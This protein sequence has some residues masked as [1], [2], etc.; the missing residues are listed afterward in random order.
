M[1]HMLQRRGC[2][3]LAVVVSILW[4]VFAPS[5]DH[6][7]TR[8]I[9]PQPS[10]LTAASCDGAPWPE[11][12]AFRP[13]DREAFE[14]EGYL[15]LR[16][17]LSPEVVAAL[18]REA[19]GACSDWPVAGMGTFNCSRGGVWTQRDA[20]RDFLYYGPVGRTI[21]GLLQ[22]AG[23]R[24]QE[25]GVFAISRG[26]PGHGWHVDMAMYGGIYGD[27][28]R[29]TRGAS[30]FVAL[31]DIDHTATGGTL[32]VSSGGHKTQCVGAAADPYGLIRRQYPLPPRAD[33]DSCYR[34]IVDNAVELS[35]RAGDAMIYHPLMP[36][37]TQATSGVRVS[38]YAR[39]IEPDAIFCHRDV[40]A[41]CGGGQPH[42]QHP[43]RPGQRA[44]H[45][46]YQQIYPL[47]A[48]E[49]AERMQPDWQ[50]PFCRWT[51]WDKAALLW[52]AINYIV[53]LRH[54]GACV[55]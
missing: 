28:H 17:F 29:S 9:A 47:L 18:R 37:R 46:C 21:Q 54:K 41:R 32:V 7:R 49:V 27:F 4:A 53:L 11:A 22:V 30:I 39:L 14:R 45:V 34:E 25:D 12:V 38:W 8:T 48:S 13:E 24:I 3:A 50:A 26:Y 33:N 52:D 40:I 1:S 51:W 19:A 20:F 10:S 31:T 2:C 36:H 55:D 5:E 23:V 44:H 42:C 6:V 16:N 15:V 35:F 43:L